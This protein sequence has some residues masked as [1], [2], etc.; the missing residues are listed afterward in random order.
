MFALVLMVVFLC[1]MIGVGLWGMRRTDSLNDFFLGGR[2][3]GPWVSALAYGTTYFSA[4]LFIGF[5]GRIGWR[6]GLN[7]LW[8]GLGNAVV[9]SLLAWLV[10]G[11]RTRRMTQNLNV[12]TMPEFLRERYDFAPLKLL[13]SGLIFLFLTAYSASVFKGL[14]HL[15]EVNF[16]ISYDIALLV[17]IAITGVYLVL[18]GYFAIVV[19]DFI[20]GVIMI[21]GCVAMLVILT[22][23]A[24]GPLDAVTAVQQRF[25]EH[26]ASA[27]PDMLLLAALVFMTSFGVW[28]MPQMVQKFYAV[29]NEAVIPKAAIVTFLFS[30][31]VAVTAYYTGALTHVFF[32]SPPIVNGKPDT[33]RLIPELL[34]T[35]VP[36][37]LMALIL[38]LILSASMST[39][40]GLVLVSASS[41]AIDLYKGH[42]NPAVSKAGSVAMIRAASAVFVAVSYIIA[43]YEFAVIVTLMS[44]SWGVIAG[45]FAAP[46]IYGLFWRRVTAAGAMAGLLT[47]VVVALV[48]FFRLGAPKAPIAASAAILAPFVVVPLVSL[49]TRPP[50]REIVDRAFA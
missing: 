27:P 8:I 28:G 25:A 40:S 18:G 21:F 32:D 12:M 5:A 41:V 3:I 33:D 7:G 4:V 19:T 46:Y 11:P 2:S 35:Q 16:R 45:A 42:I 37:A 14:G 6:Y 38:L 15:F 24:G 29:K 34:R 10:L 26:S 50:R 23:K 1:V 31:L 30:L 43:R 17:M 47:G 9:G 49:F 39:L 36:E 22:A 44:V 20:Q 13:A 48:L